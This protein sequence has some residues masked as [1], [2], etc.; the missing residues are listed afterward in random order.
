[1]GASP[2]I[3]QALLY[4]IKEEPRSRVE[5]SFEGGVLEI[6]IKAPNLSSLQATVNGW[7]RM[8]KALVKIEEVVSWPRR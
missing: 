3:Y 7:L 5:L 2:E 4:E 6:R 1:M 8:Y